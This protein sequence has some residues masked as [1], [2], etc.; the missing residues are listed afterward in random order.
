MVWIW[1]A[2][3]SCAVVSEAYSLKPKIV[4]KKEWVYEHQN[5]RQKLTLAATLTLGHM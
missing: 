1:H 4:K 2:R 5:A 3:V